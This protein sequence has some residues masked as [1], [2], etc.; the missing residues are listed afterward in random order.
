MSRNFSVSG[1]FSSMANT[2]KDYLQDIYN[3]TKNVDRNIR[4]ITNPTRK[5]LAEYTIPLANKYED[6]REFLLANESK[7]KGFSSKGNERH[8]EYLKGVAEISVNLATTMKRITTM[9]DNAKTSGESI[10]Y[11]DYLKQVSDIKDF[12]EEGLKL[13]WD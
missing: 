6:Y 1:D 2:I 12:A 7:I 3:E 8:S 9:L 11:L 4:N 5:Q 13:S 10:Y